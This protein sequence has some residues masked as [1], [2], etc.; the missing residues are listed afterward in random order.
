MVRTKEMAKRRV[1]GALVKPEPD[2]DGGRKARR[3]RPGTRAL[4]EI[5]KA[6]GSNGVKGVPRASFAKLVR[7]L[8]LMTCAS[9]NRRC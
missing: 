4:R 8:L 6:Q 2:K 1:K 5:R 9:Q 3:L 7:K